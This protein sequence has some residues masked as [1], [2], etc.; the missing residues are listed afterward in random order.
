MRNY[1]LLGKRQDN[2]V[3]FLHAQNRFVYRGTTTTDVHDALLCKT[4]EEAVR[5]RE[6]YGEQWIVCTIDVHN[7]CPEH[8]NCSSCAWHGPCP[9][10]TW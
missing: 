5:L 9:K 3:H 7:V 6:V 4:R 8:Y 10:H 2:Q 1:Y